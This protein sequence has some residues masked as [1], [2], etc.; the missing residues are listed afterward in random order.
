M[1]QRLSDSGGLTDTVTS[2]SQS[3]AYELAS[4]VT[5]GTDSMYPQNIFIQIQ[6]FSNTKPRNHNRHNSVYP[7]NIKP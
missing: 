2:E 4:F 3:L 5:K 1:L 6:L 7:D